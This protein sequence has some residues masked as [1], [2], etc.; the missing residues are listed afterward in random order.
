MEKPVTVDGPSTRR[1]LALAEE[2]VKKNLKVGV[3]LMWRHC[4]A[5]RALHDRVKAG[6]IGDIITLRAYRMHGPL[7]S[8]LSEPKPAGISDLMYQIRNFHSYIWASG[9]CYNDFYIHNIDE[10]CWMKGAWPV[11]A[12][13]CGGRHYRGE[14]RRSE[15]RQLLGGIHV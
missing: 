15:L 10:C 12:Q 14:L 11:E 13:A 4:R 8:F 6:E 3:G 7:G 1:T 9:G 2:S 5:R